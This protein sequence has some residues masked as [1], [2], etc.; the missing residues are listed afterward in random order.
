MSFKMSVIEVAIVSMKVRPIYMMVTFL[1]HFFSW[2]TSHYYYCPQVVIVC[3]VE[4]MR[5]WKSL[6]V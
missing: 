2:M 6:D 3:V 4:V 1:S 5:D